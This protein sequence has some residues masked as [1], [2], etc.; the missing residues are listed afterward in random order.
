VIA[1]MTH[2]AVSS[3]MAE[4]IS[5]IPTFRRIKPISRTTIATIFTEAIDNAVPRNS[6]VM[7]R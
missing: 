1:T 3:M 2:P 6:E 4:A 7:I 5:A